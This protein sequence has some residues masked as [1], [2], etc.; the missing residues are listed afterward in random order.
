VKLKAGVFLFITII[1]AQTVKA[2]TIINLDATSSSASSVTDTLSAGT[3][4]VSIVGTNVAGALYSGWNSS[5]GASS[6]NLWTDRY[7]IDFCGGTC[8]VIFV[9]NNNPGYATASA[10]LSSY[11]AAT[12]LTSLVVGTSSTGSVANPFT[13]TLAA[14]Q[15]LT[16]EVPDA[17]SFSDDSGGLS[18]QVTQAG[19]ATPEP[20]SFVLI[21]LGL[22]GVGLYHRKKCP[23]P[24]ETPLPP[25]TSST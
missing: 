1:G 4:S 19:S 5:L 24:S 21:G 23:S 6:N 15:T 3:Y 13:F 22:V 7:E 11:Q 16:F 17:G 10:A 2:S 8:G 12:T 18:L 25:T 20:A 14:P 9:M